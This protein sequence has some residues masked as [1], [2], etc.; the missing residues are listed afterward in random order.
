MKERIVA[1]SRF[2][3]NPS[4]KSYAKKYG[5]FLHRADSRALQSVQP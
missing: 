3:R 2:E 5:G 4:I 1:V